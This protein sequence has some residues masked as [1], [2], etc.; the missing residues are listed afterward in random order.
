M[1]ELAAIKDEKGIIYYVIYYN[2]KYNELFVVPK[3][4][5]NKKIENI[6]KIINKLDFPIIKESKYLKRKAILFPIYKIKVYYNPISK[7]KR[8][9]E[10]PRDETELRV[11]ELVEFLVEES[12]EELRNFG[13]GGSILIGIHNK[14]SDIDLAY[15]GENHERVYQALLKLREK[16]I[17]RPLDEEDII[18]LYNERKLENV[19][20]FD[21][22][23]NIEKRK[24]I[25]GRFKDKI[26]SIKL[27]L[28]KDFEPR[29]VLGIREYEFIIRDNSLSYT[30][31]SVY[32]AERIDNTEIYEIVSYKFRYSEMLKNGEK[33]SVRGMLEE[34]KTGSVRLVLHS[35]ED[36]IKPIE[37]KA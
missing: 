9:M 23:K 28:N 24:K 21:L 3:Y 37:V 17:L 19:I 33:V 15:Y 34:D 30:F 7:L 10:E 8:I 20:E 1:R 25:E 31:P 27:I 13:I 22:F 29:K 5:N 32:K 11:K 14:D 12:K 2:K 6:N 18:K 16:N 26:Y 4:L 36:Y 35:N